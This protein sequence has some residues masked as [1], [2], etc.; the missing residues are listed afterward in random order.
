NRLQQ[1]V[2]NLLSNAVKF[3]RAGGRVQI[4]LERVNSKIE[5]VVTDTGIGIKRDFL[6]FVFDR[7]RQADATA[8]RSYGGLGLGLA[9]VRHLVERHGGEVQ[10]DS[11]GEGKGATFTVRLPILAVYQ[12]DHFGDRTPRTDGNLPQTPNLDR[13]DGL[14]ILVVDDEPDSCELLKTMIERS[15]A[16]VTIAASAEEGLTVLAGSNFDVIVSDVGMPRTDGYQF[17]QQVRE[18]PADG[19]SRIPAVALTAYARAEDRLRALRAGYQM[20]IPKPIE[21]AELV[22]VIANLG[23]RHSAFSN[24]NKTL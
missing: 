23:R 17:M 16:E 8:T 4:R 15:G 11:E 22:S 20:H 18:L 7:F 3:T 2:W 6:P 13:L 10:A 24:A 14:K 19:K 1:V 12:R 5:I 9:I 21:Y